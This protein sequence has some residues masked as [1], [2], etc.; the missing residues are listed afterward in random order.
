MTQA[1]LD[2]LT[3]ISQT[4][5]EGLYARYEEAKRQGY[6]GTYSQYEREQRDL[7][8][9]IMASKEETPTTEAGSRKPNYPLIIGLVGGAVL[10]TVVIV[11]LAR[12]K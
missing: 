6:T 1:Q 2:S 12:K 9:A 3:G 4:V 5:E 7:H 8:N 11:V 10:L